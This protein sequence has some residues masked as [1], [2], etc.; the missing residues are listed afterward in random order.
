MGEWL[1]EFSWLRFG[2]IAFTGANWKQPISF[3]RLRHIQSS[4]QTI[5]RVLTNLCLILMS[6][7]AERRSR[8]TNHSEVTQWA[9][10][11]EAGELGW[12]QGRLFLS[13]CLQAFPVG[14]LQAFFSAT[15]IAPAEGVGG[16]RREG[17]RRGAYNLHALCH[18]KGI[19]SYPGGVFLATRREKFCLVWIA[20]LACF[21][22]SSLDL[23]VLDLQMGK[24]CLCKE[25][26]FVRLSPLLSPQRKMEMNVSRWAL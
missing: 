10:R 9:L 21:V 22:L 4:N 8:R 1:E 20:L 14:G 3:C 18:L 17:G 2:M 12:N 16:G 25:S 5:F 11:R 26:R 23:F 7:N 19:N 24:G 15:E 6:A 13:A